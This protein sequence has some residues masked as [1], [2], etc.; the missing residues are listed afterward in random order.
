M[1]E[2]G[3]KARSVAGGGLILMGN[4][5]TGGL[6]GKVYPQ[7]SGIRCWGGGAT[8]REN[9]EFWRLYNVVLSILLKRTPVKYQ[10]EV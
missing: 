10:T 3:N 6:G 2:D 8:P 7:P 4:K 1:L 9:Y 5:P